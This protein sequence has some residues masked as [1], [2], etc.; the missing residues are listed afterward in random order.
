MKKTVGGRCGG[1]AGAGSLGLKGGRGIY[2]K[3]TLTMF[4]PCYLV[5]IDTES[6]REARG[7][8]YR[9]KRRLF[10]QCNDKTNMYSLFISF[11]YYIVKFLEALTD[12]ATIIC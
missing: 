5:L 1:E 7:C 8:G 10:S 6:L 11:L 9:A 4:A 2:R 12:C 3:K